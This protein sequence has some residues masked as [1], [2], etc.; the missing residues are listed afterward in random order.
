MTYPN[1]SIRVVGGHRLQGKVVAAGAKNA[2]LPILASTI[3]LDGETMLHNIPELADVN[4]M[5]RM[6]N[7]L[8]VRTEYGINDNVHCLNTKKIKHLAPYELVT[9]MRASFFVAGPILAKT[10][11]AKISLPGGCL[12]GK[13]PVDIHLDGFKALGAHITLENGFVKVI[14]DSKYGRIATPAKKVKHRPNPIPVKI[15]NNASKI[16]FVFKHRNV[17]YKSFACQI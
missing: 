11:Y 2:I 16:N 17:W 8:N 13:R 10:G 14:F 9:A 4:N 1:T 15:I 6:L 5:I 3:M 12:I 7:A